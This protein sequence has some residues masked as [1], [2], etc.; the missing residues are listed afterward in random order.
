LKRSGKLACRVDGCAKGVP[1]SLNPEVVCMTHYL[2]GA[3]EELELAAAQCREGQPIPPVVLDKLRTQAEYAVQ[4]LPDGR[5]VNELREKERI[6][7]FL[8]GLANLHEYLS[9][10]VSLVGRTR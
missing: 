9:H 7:E 10:N 5:V 6:L 1:A 8:L 2:Q 4:F 3:M